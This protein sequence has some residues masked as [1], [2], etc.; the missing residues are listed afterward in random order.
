MSGAPSQSLVQWFVGID[1]GNTEHAVCVLEAQGE[2]VA[3]RRIL[4]TATALGELVAWLLDVAGGERAALAVAIEVPRGPVVELFLERGI[5]VHSLN[6]KQLDRFRDR[7]SPSGAKDDRRDAWVLARALRSDGE[8][9]RVLT[10]ESPAVLQLREWT[11]T[12]AEL[13]V[14]LGRLT[15]RLREQL[16]RYYPQ[17]LAVVP[18]ADEPWL[19]AVL[20]RAPTPAAGTQLSLR[21]IRALLKAHRIRRLDAAAVQAALRTPALVVAPG[22]VEAAA[23]HVAL[24]LPRLMLVQAQRQ[25]CHKALDTLL[26]QLE[27]LEQLAGPPAG[28]GAGPATTGPSDAAILRSLPGAGRLVTG[29]LLAEAS[30]V[31][32][33]REHQM[34]R[35]W[36]G[37]APITKQTGTKK[38]RT[39]HMRYA[40]HRRLRAACFFWA[41]ASLKRD[42]ASKAYYAQLKAR[43]HSH[44]RA[45][46][47]VADR[48]LRILFAMLANR[49][50]YD[51]SRFPVPA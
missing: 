23:A 47:S 18:A 22:T 27:Q 2:V 41:F 17:L 6:P 16:Q 35:S 30:D 26:E 19:W 37:L 50:L 14:E 42:P 3:E 5:A 39:V 32:A 51:P 21:T 1:W 8:C 24:L 38:T 46:R 4:H 13:V 25:Q 43:G 10:V 12:E 29:T 11:R 49:T 34:L 20:T 9:F 33:A 36:T 48:L 45:L 40:C 28:P 7:W 44:A 31:I 15:N